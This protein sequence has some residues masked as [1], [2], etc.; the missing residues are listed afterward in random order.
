MITDNAHIESR[1]AG[2]HYNGFSISPDGNFAVFR[3]TTHVTDPGVQ[4]G[5]NQ[6]NHIYVYDRVS[7]TTQLLT[8]PDNNNNTPYTI[9]DQPAIGG[10]LIVFSSTDFSNPS[11]PPVRHLI[12]TNLQGHIVTDL[13]TA[14]F[15]ITEPSDPSQPQTDLQTPDISNNGRYLTV[16]AVAHQDDAN[17][18]PVGTATLYTYDRVTQTY[19]VIATTSAT[20]D[21][22]QASMD[23]SGRYVVFQSDD[24]S[25]DT[26]AGGVADNHLNIFVF[27]RQA[28]G[29]QGG[30]IG[31]TDRAGFQANGDSFR[32]SISPDGRY[33]ILASNATNLVSGDTDGVGDTFVYDLQTQT[34]QRISVAADGTQ[35][36][37]DSTLGADISFNGGFAVFGS[38]A[39]DLVG[40]NNSAGNSNIFIVDRT[41]GTAGAVVEDNTTPAFQGAAPNSL[42]TYGGFNFS[43][44]DPTDT[45]TI[46]VTG[47]AIDTSKAP[48]GFIVPSGGLGTFTPTLFDGIDQVG[49]TFTVDNSLVQGLN[50][51]QQIRQT[52]TIQIANN[53]GGT[54]TQNVTIA[55]AGE[56]DPPVITSNP[57]QSGV[58][59]VNA[60]SVA[61]GRLTSSDAD[62]GDTATWTI[63]GGARELPPNYQFTID[64]FKVVKGGSTIFD[65]SFNGTAPPSGPSFGSANPIY[66]A[67]GGFTDGTDAASRSV[68]LLTG[69]NAV[70]QGTRGANLNDVFGEFATLNSNVDP[71]STLGLKSGQAFNASGTFDLVAP[72]SAND[73]YGIRLSDRVSGG[74]G[75]QPGTQTVEL[76]IVAG[77]TTGTEA[78]QLRE[79]DFANST[80]TVLQTI[81]LGNVGTD[82]QIAL[83]LSNNPASN[84]NIHASYQL[85][86][87]GVAVGSATTFEATGRIFDN[88]DWTRAQF[89]G[90]S[91]AQPSA[92]SSADSVLH[93]TYGTLDITQSGAWIYS[94]NEGLAATQALA[95]GQ[96]AVDS[97]TAQVTD[98]TGLSATQVINITVNGAIYAPVLDSFT[99]PFVAPGHEPGLYQAPYTTNYNDPN[100]GDPP[101]PSGLAISAV[102]ADPATQGVWQY[103]GDGGWITINA[104]DV[105]V[106]HA[107]A[108]N[109]ASALRFVPVNGYTGA[110]S[111]TVYALD[112]NLGQNSGSGVAYIDVTQHGGSTHISNPATISAPVGAPPTVSSE[113]GLSVRR[114][115]SVVL[116][117]TNLL[118]TDPNTDPDNLTYT[119][120][121]I[122]NGRIVRAGHPYAAITQFTDAELRAGHILF[123][124]DGSSVTST[125][126]TVTLSDGL[127]TSTSQ[128][129]NV[130][131][132]ARPGNFW[133]SVLFPP[134]ETAGQH[135]F[136]GS[137]SVNQLTGFVG[138]EYASTS[139]Y[140]TANPA[141]PYSLT[142]NAFALDPFMLRWSTGS[143]A[144]E[145]SLVTLPSR[146]SIG[147]PNFNY[148]NNVVQ[149][150]GIV[151]FETQA[152]GHN[153]LNRTIVQTGSTSNNL[154]FNPGQSQSFTQIEDLGDASA[155][156]TYNVRVVPRQSGS[157][158]TLS[159]YAVVWDVFNSS[160]QTYT[161]QLQT[162]NADNTTLSN[163]VITALS[164]SGVTNILNAPAWD[165]K[166][167]GSNG[168]GYEFVQAVHDSG[169]NLDDLSFAGYNTNGS[170]NGSFNITIT[171]DLSH[172]AP[173]AIN[174]IT[175]ELVTGLA[176]FPG[177]PA[178]ALQIA[179]MPLAG[180]GFAVA[181]SETVSDSNGS[182]N[183][184][185][186]DIAKTGTSAS[187]HGVTF[188]I[189]DGNG[190]Q[191]VRVLTINNPLVDGG[192]SVAVLAYGDST[193]THIREYSDGTNALSLLASI[194][195]TLGP[196]DNLTSLGD[197]RIVVGYDQTVA[198]DQ[199]TQHRF[200]IYDLRTAALNETLSTGHQ[201]YIAGTHFNDQV[202][203]ENSQSNAYEFTG[204]NTSGPTVPQDAFTGG[205][206]GW[207][208]AVM[209]DAF[210]NYV[211]GQTLING[212]LTTTLTNN[213][214]P[215]H[216][217][218]LTLNSVQ[219]VAFAPTSDPMPDA[220][221]TIHAS[222]GSLLILGPV[223]NHIDV[224]DS[225]GVELYASGAGNPVG[226]ASGGLTF[227]G[228]GA[229]LH[230]DAGASQFT[231]QI[232]GIVGNFIH[233]E[234]WDSATTQTSFNGSVLTVTD[235]THFGATAAQ[236]TI[237]GLSASVPFYV[238]DDGNG[239]PV[240][241][242]DHP[243]V[244]VPDSIIA[245][246]DLLQSSSSVLIPGYLLTENDTDADLN[247]NVGEHLSVSAVDTSQTLGS[248]LLQGTDV[249]YTKS[250]GFT[251]PGAGQ[252]ATDQFGYTVTDATGITS[253]THVTLTVEGGTSI[254]GT[255]GNDVFVTGNGTHTLT[256]GSGSDTFVFTPNN[257]NDTITDFQIGQD[258]IQLD[259]FFSSNTDPAFTAFLSNLQA[260]S[261]GV[262]TISDSSHL[263]GLTITLNNVSVNQL[264][265]SDFIIHS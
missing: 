180:Q 263:P 261:N 213:G 50:A 142:E 225:T 71:N 31:I 98:S 265:A 55:I 232:D 209:P 239:H 139:N 11:A 131:V 2:E 123:V 64:E 90:T 62:L 214:D 246:A 24:N 97:F 108:I 114:G 238:M 115:D 235:A 143:S 234:G 67:S 113:S 211:V 79:I 116:T 66:F 77:A 194:D 248:V 149:P 1:P 176:P 103:Q 30:I 87:L 146:T 191:S 160:A 181:W 39:G 137:L 178:S 187:T 6:I 73:V 22:W 117:T 192:T 145:T 200:V 40:G 206:G 101:T 175:Q 92:S 4:G 70:F 44:V 112:A 136:I 259:G 91:F 75:A 210:S 190:P 203:G 258:H 53:H 242:T 12:V 69:T 243:P 65:D 227:T 127:A 182:H 249:L 121:Q 126:F 236:F 29:G 230:L 125:S 186:F 56:P 118:G 41:A 201:N 80:S 105:S 37:G 163:G 233:L 140:N 119:V 58:V 171:P 43:D 89:F 13:T 52:Y 129:V 220:N 202:T 226:S 94:L 72:T 19:Q 93:G 45:H 174:H 141:G 47:V 150:E 78:V 221:G 18:T 110:P 135:D 84:G 51:F 204:L 138:L 74:T 42:T 85:L 177:G 155:N 262:N 154:I 193:G 219:A 21:N 120:T 151:V 188:Q 130:S 86:H 157:P 156:T 104:S 152:N 57:V 46:Q 158:S 54:V 167:S 185:E 153:V 32:A 17:F 168:S 102:N 169:S 35:G 217:G 23:N 3:G 189:P 111:L 183:Q 218:V 207:N 59:G 159:S 231:G 222:G 28:N 83:S 216:S 241:G 5:S 128:Q 7:D 36:N 165:F 95:A 256:G 144:I 224:G 147:L 254:V 264:H 99:L 109:Y 255:G 196:Y 250:A 166:N 198:A 76:A 20:D 10:H 245:S 257:G 244:A 195:N 33:V 8:N 251:L 38:V 82:D 148:P 237:S 96:S 25:L 26:K 106:T 197:G 27:D 68:A 15:G 100:P 208:V 162:F 122:A 132:L 63:Q 184:V 133:S 179:P 199:T 260:Q 228:H 172:Y 252:S 81:Q 9:N 88:E 48:A 124:Q 164:R 60:A 212:V 61:T 161:V 205:S 173:G 253:S 215:V 49:W 229:I 247:S 34:F 16:W 134:A 107:L 240:I 14:S 223:S 170:G